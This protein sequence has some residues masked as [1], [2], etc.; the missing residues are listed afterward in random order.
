MPPTD[1]TE[2]AW[3]ANQAAVNAAQFRTT[4]WTVV[5]AA[6]DRSSPG[7]EAALAKLC[8]TYWLPVYAFIRKRGRSPGQTQDF[9]PEFFA[10]FLE[11]NYIARAERPRRRFRA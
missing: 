1:P 4:L 6:G 10:R 2:G 7:S 11:K 8:Q 5:L 3:F 9:T